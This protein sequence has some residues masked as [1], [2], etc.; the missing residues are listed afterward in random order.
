MCSSP[1]LYAAS[2]PVLA[3]YLRR[4]QAWLDKAA[5]QLDAA[6]GSEAAL[7]QT[8]LAPGMFTLAQQIHTAAGFAQ[9]ACAPLAEVEMPALGQGDAASL[10]EL[11]ARLAR[12][13]A[14]V[15]SLDAAALRAAAGRRLRTQA[16][17]AWLEL[18]SAEFLQLY[19]LPNFFFH[20]GMA[21]A[22]LRQA[23]V[24]LGKPDF[25]GWH[26]YPDGFSF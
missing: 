18:E 26:R 1:D 17:E 12:A 20:L 21:Y 23:G 13:L 22:L 24:P 9:R 15:E 4:A 3:R 10:A 8:R 5:A 11:Q 14:F 2:V 25:D 19:A 16:G 7:L 6:G